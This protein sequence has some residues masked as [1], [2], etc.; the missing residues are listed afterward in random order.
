[1]CETQ[2]DPT[3]AFLNVNKPSEL[4]LRERVQETAGKMTAKEVKSDED[5]E[6]QREHCTKAVIIVIELRENVV[7]EATKNV[8]NIKEKAAEESKVIG[9][10]SVAESGSEFQGK[11]IQK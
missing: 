4:A 5:S 1:M 2:R 9:D 11:I 7:H 6:V 3:Q 10:L 8:K